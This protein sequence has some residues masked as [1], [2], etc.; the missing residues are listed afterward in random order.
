MSAYRDRLTP[1]GQAA[2]RQTI[3]TGHVVYQT[4]DFELLGEVLH[5]RNAPQSTAPAGS[6]W[7]A[8]G[9]ISRQFG[10]IRP[11]LRY[12]Y[13]KA[14]AADPLFAAVGRR[15]GPLAGLRFTL[16]ER[17]MIK[18]E[19]QRTARRGLPTAR[20]HRPSGVHFL[21]GP[22]IMPA[23]GWERIAAVGLLMILGAW[24]PLSGQ[25]TAFKVVVHV[26]NPV[27][28]M[29]R[30]QLADLFLKRVSRWPDGRKVQLIDQAPDAPVRASFSSAI[31]GKP[32]QAIQSYWQQ[33]IFSRRDV[34]PP[35]A[36]SDQAI[37]AYVHAHPEALGYLRS[38]T[39]L[40]PDC[41]IVD[42]K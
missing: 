39:P 5:I 9:Q 10:R 14:P 25:A 17:A 30:D 41:R 28:A 38:D 20:I 35:E 15:D 1:Q 18:G 40:C 33:K 11:Y 6:T 7:G 37:L 32:V 27:T 19:Y 4:L 29:T 22:G 3:L 23:K 34:P 8:Y 2:V 21:V 26:T 31:F 36:S 16:V 24:Q 42:V 13:T 12:E